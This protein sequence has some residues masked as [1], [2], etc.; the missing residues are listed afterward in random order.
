MD[1]SMRLRLAVLSLPFLLCGIVQVMS[2]GAQDSTGRVPATQ[3]IRSTVRALILICDIWEAPDGDPM[4]I[5]IYDTCQSYTSG[6]G[7][8]I[9]QQG[10]I[11]TNAHVALNYQTGQPQWLLIG[12]TT[13]PRE[14]PTFTFFARAIVYDAALDLAVVAPTYTLDGR[15]IEEGDVNLLPL[16]MARNEQAVELEQP[17][18]LIGYPIVGGITV[19]IDNAVVSGF[20]PDP[21]VPELAG[22]AWIKTNPAGG[23]GISGGTAVNDDGILIGVPS[24]VGGAE[25]RCYDANGDGQNDPATECVATGGETGYTRPIPE[26]YDLLRKKARQSGQLNSGGD[27]D[28]SNPT[29]EGVTITGRIV[30]ADTGDPIEGAYVLV[31]QPGVTVQEAIDENDPD[32]TYA[33]GQTNSRGRYILNNPVARNQGYGVLVYAPDYQPIL[34]DDIVLATDGDPSTKDVGT[35]ELPSAE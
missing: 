16:P 22:S 24:A 33:Y 18:R 17:I 10:L 34:G 21:N 35:W 6:S 8:I 1:M 12:L 30:S 13:D 20:S 15:A 32:N 14:L 31:F 23:P 28:E 5:P 26:A 11:L 27:D 25:I 9:S 4:G 7:T 29:D 2:T 3:I 19:T